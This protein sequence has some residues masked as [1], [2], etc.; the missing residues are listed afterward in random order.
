[1]E[2]PKKKK[3]TIKEAKLVKAKIQGKTHKEAYKEAGYSLSKS[4]HSNVSNT[5]KIL[6]KPHVKEAFNKAL[7]KA[8][9]TEERLAIKL[10]EGLDATKAV[11]M[12]KE[13]TESFVDVQPDYAIRHKYLETALKVKGIGNNDNQANNYVQIIKEQV[14]KYV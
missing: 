5:D 7:E 6:N 4:E 10:S 13:S 9:I 2:K 1:M 14:N 3:L 12:G 8:N 11:V